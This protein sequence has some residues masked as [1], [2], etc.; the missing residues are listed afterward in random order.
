MLEL[1]NPDTDKE[2]R[3]KIMPFNKYALKSID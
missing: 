3:A 1:V 2:K